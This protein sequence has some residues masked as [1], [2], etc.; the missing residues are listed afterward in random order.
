MTAERTAS[1]QAEGMGHLARHVA[2]PALMS[3][4]FFSVALTPVSVLGCRGRGLLAL[5]IALTSGIWAL[6]AAVTG[7]KKRARGE[8][9]AFWW[10]ISAMVLTI[11]VVAMLVMA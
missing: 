1:R 5:L 4:V 11:P 6:G 8:G 9:D 7:V 2:L 3:A 10:V